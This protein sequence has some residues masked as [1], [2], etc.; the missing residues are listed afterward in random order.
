MAEGGLPDYKI[1]VIE[2]LFALESA[3]P[4]VEQR[5]REMIENLKD[6][7]PELA[8]HFSEKVKTIQ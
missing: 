7:D 4:K 3:S 5:L 1:N 2:E 8:L 6:I